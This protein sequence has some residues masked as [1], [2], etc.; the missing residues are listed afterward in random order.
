MDRKAKSFGH[1]GE[2]KALRA[3]VKSESDGSGNATMVVCHLGVPGCGWLPQLPE[4]SS[5]PVSITTTSAIQ[6]LRI[7]WEA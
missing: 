7:L 2:I 3:R 6:L 4:I 1:L 5:L